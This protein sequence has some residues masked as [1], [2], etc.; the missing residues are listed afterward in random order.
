[1]VA[2]H[3][4]QSRQVGVQLLPCGEIGATATRRWAQRQ[5]AGEHA[6]KGGVGR[7]EHGDALGLPH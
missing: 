6:L 5:A 3:L 7:H 1:M 4:I 2:E